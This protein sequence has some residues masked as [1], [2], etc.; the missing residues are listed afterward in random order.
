VKAVRGLDQKSYPEI[1]PNL[2]FVKG[3]PLVKCLRLSQ[4]PGMIAR[5]VVVDFKKNCNGLSGRVDY[6]HLFSF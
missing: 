1:T 4:G 6:K 2:G 5:K 3:H